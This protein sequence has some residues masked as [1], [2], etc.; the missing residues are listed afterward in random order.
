[1]QGITAVSSKVSDDYVREKLPDGKFKPE[2]Y[3]FADGGNWGGEIRD[4][5]IDRLRFIDVARVIAAPLAGRNFLPARDPKATRLLI[6]VY[7]GTTDVPGPTSDSMALPKLQ[8]ANQEMNKWLVRSNVDPRTKYASGPTGL[9]DDAMDQMTVATMLVNME[10]R[11]ND[12]VDLRNARLL[13]YDSAGL[14]GTDEGNY[15]RGTALGMERTDLYADIEE[16]RYFVVL[17]AYDFQ[18][19]WKDRKH[20]LLWETRFSINERRNAFDKALPFMARYASRYFGEPSNGLIREAVPE[21]HVEMGE[22]K[23]VKDGPDAGP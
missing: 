16:N 8:A 12:A 4:Q 9:V 17:M 6:M 7:W 13:G 14:I 10:N 15:V 23:L 20:K 2:Y 5:T 11:Q 21:G 3:A 19:L 22:P 1:V 18:I